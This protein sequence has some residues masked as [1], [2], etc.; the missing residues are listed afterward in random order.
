MKGRLGHT[1]ELAS[2]TG[3]PSVSGNRSAQVAAEMK[4]QQVYEC[5]SQE[6]LSPYALTLLEALLSPP[7]GAKS[8]QPGLTIRP[9]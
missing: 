4:S 5:C 6:R 9:L 1:Q 8:F 7:L 3:S 2:W